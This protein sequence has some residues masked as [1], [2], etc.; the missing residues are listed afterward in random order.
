MFS[1]S[2]MRLWILQFHEDQ[3]WYTWNL[4][5]QGGFILCLPECTSSLHLSHCKMEETRRMIA[6]SKADE[7]ISPPKRKCE[8][9]GV[10]DRKCLVFE[11]SKE[12]YWYKLFMFCCLI[13]KEK[14]HFKMPPSNS[15][16]ETHCILY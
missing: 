12:M 5:F 2:F 4:N 8:M 1:S 3:S 10:N 14:F 11:E 13:P 16:F 7:M 6:I 9:C 15:A